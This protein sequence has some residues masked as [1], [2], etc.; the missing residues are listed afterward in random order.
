MTCIHSSHE[1]QKAIP[2]H[3]N[4]S[5]QRRG[6]EALRVRE[7]HGFNARSRSEDSPG[8][9]NDRL[10]TLCDGRRGLRTGLAAEIREPAPEPGNPA[11]PIL[12]FMAS[13]DALDRC[14]EIIDPFGWQLEN[15][16]RNP[17]FQNAHQYGDII[18][19]L[20]KALITQVRDLPGPD[21]RLRP[22]LFQRIEFAVDANPMARIAYGLYKGKFLNA[23]SVGF[24][25]LR[26]LNA[27][28]TEHSL[29]ERRR[30]AGLDGRIAEPERRRDLSADV[31][32][33]AP[34]GASESLSRRD[35]GVPAFRR[36]YLFQELLE[37]SAV[38][39][40]ANPEALQL[41]LKAGA[42]ERSD[43]KALLDLFS[44]LSSPA[45]APLS[46]TDS[47]THS[48]T[49]GLSAGTVANPSARGDGANGAQ[50]L[51]LARALRNLLRRA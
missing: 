8:E 37:V 13:S 18:F 31:P 12:D 5:P 43:L 1:P 30:L 46:L 6:E 50:L 36:K 28:G 15:Y 48:R 27:D 4:P 29:S 19:T 44:K 14:G 51:Q 11:A 2:P 9:F 26:W 16:R 33:S 47:P 38:G 40:P 39:I 25:P 3:P 41:G 22:A 20:G 23:V 42:I 35:V 24:V 17:V 21:G 34:A 10:V 45:D 7:V 49:N 32:I